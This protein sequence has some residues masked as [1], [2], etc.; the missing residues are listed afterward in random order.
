VLGRL[1]DV[2]NPSEGEE[3]NVSQRLV[4]VYLRGAKM[5]RVTAVIDAVID[6]MP[7]EQRTPAAFATFPEALRPLVPLLPKWAIDDDDERSRKLRRCTPSSRQK[8][9]DTVIPLLPAIDS[10]LDGFGTNPP[11]EACALGSLAQAALEAQ[12]LLRDN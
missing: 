5:D 7:H 1:L 3:M 9:V 8:L 12:S 2:I 4:R 10:F 11:E 6:I